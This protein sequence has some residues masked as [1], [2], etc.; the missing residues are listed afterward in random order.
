MNYAKPEVTLL[1]S[2][3]HVIQGSTSKMQ[4]LED[5]KSELFVVTISAYESDE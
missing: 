5:S 4:G 1:A 3:T 2:A